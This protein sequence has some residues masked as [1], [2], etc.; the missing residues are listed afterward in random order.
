[1]NSATEATASATREHDLLAQPEFDPA[2][3]AHEHRQRRRDQQAGA[4]DQRGEHQERQR[5]HH[6]GPQMPARQLRSADER[7]AQH[8]DDA[9]G[10]QQPAQQQRKIAGAHPH[11]GPDWIVSPEP[12]AGCSGSDEHQPGDRILIEP[13]SRTQ[14]RSLRIRVNCCAHTRRQWARAATGCCRAGAPANRA[15]PR[16]RHRGRARCCI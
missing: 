12:Q 2:Q 11:G 4:I 3:S 15:S 8:V 7:A 14:G 6:H 9:E 10:D 1:M 16:T 13:C 5:H